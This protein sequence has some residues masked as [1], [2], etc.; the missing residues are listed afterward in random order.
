MRIQKTLNL[1]ISNQEQKLSIHRYQ[2]SKQVP[3]A[4]HCFLST[5]EKFN[6][7]Y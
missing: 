4:R 2:S 6:I 3:S 1:L 7:S 5:P